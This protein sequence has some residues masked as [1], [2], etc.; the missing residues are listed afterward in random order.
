MVIHFFMA[1]PF[2][3]LDLTLQVK[4]YSSYHAKSIFVFV[5]GVWREGL[6]SQDSGPTRDSLI[7]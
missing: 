4:L 5:I 3:L 7:S 2:I 1:Y 6:M